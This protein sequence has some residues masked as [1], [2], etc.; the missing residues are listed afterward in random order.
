[1]VLVEPPIDISK[2]VTQTPT[3]SGKKNI[4]TVKSGDVLGVI[5]EK[6]SVS[7]RQLRS[8]NNLRGNMIK[9]GQ[10]LVI[11]SDKYEAKSSS[12]NKVVKQES[13][14]NGY[15]Y[16]TIRRGDTLWDIAKLYPGVSADDI[17]RLNPG[18]SSKNLKLGQKIK[19]KPASS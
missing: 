19:I 16:H 10:K 17:K 14:D 4:Y 2:P 11:Y 1:M 12:S 9:P 18:L 3:G 8:W 15:I 6:H 5:A 13:T 7:V